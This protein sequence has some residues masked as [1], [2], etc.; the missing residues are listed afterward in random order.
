MF[1]GTSTIFEWSCF[2]SF[3]L[4][5]VRVLVLAGIFFDLPGAKTGRRFYAA[6]PAMASEIPSRAAMIEF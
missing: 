4:H 3:S 6:A 1:S 5:E 2:S